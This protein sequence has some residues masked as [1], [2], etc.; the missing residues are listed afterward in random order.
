M[1]IIHLID[2]G[3]PSSAAVVALEGSG[4]PHSLRALVSNDALL[5]PDPALRMTLEELLTLY[6]GPVHGAAV[7]PDDGVATS[8]TCCAQSLSN[9]SHASTGASSMSARCPSPSLSLSTG[10]PCVTLEQTAAG[11]GSISFTSSRLSH[12]VPSTCPPP[13]LAEQ[14]RRGL[15]ATLKQLL[16]DKD[17]EAT[18]GN[19]RP[20]SQVVVYGMGGCG[21]STLASSMLRSEE[22]Q[23]AFAGG[24]CWVSVGQLPEFDF[25]LHTLLVQLSPSSASYGVKGIAALSELIE[26]V[27]EAAAAEGR[28]VLCVLDDVWNAEHAHVLG[29]PLKAATVLV[30]TRIRGIIPE[31][32]ELHCSLMESEEAIALL[33]QAGGVLSPDAAGLRVAKQAVELCGRLALVPNRMLTCCVCASSN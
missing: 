12:R 18:G 13:P 25:L 21:K 30:T 6:P 22:V 32:R 5:N 33:L 1:N 2:L 4:H 15:F 19:V 23:T 11:V 20:G 14:P 3:T 27:T 26:T 31:A 16:L 10:P 29:A 24:L 7:R 9:E 8:S 28:R 17:A